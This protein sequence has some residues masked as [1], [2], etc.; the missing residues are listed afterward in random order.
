[1]AKYMLIAS[2]TAEGAKGVL[3]DGGSARRDQAE[4]AVKSV[5]GS[6][7]S[8]YFAF[9]ADDAYV[10]VD[11]PDHASAAAASLTVSSSGAVTVRTVPLI[12]PEEIDEAAKKTVKYT[13]PGK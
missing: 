8:F 10:I 13:P 5:G 3:K 11:M 9:G 1:M 12:M 4:S 2:Y 6:V 7:E